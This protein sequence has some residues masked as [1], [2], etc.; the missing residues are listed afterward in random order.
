MI[1]PKVIDQD[2]PSIL[3]LPTTVEINL[4]CHVDTL[5]TAHTKDLSTQAFDHYNDVHVFDGLG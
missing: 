5:A 1:E 2:V 3:G 4:A